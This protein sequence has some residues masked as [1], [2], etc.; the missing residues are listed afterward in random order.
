MLMSVREKK[1]SKEIAQQSIQK[2]Q[3]DTL[4]RLSNPIFLTS[5]SDTPKYLESVQ[6]NKPHSQV[7]SDERSESSFA[8]FVKPPEGH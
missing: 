1:R 4:L 8:Q 6:G 3:S 5:S 2:A 7:C